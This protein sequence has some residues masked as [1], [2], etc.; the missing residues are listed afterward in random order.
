MASLAALGD[1]PKAHMTF[2]LQITNGLLQKGKGRR[3][4]NNHTCVYL[5]IH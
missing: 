4:G 2:T 1:H 5:W 3:G